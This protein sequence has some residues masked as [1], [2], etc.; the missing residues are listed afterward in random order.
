MIRKYIVL[1]ICGTTRL[2]VDLI[3]VIRSFTEGIRE[4]QCWI[5]HGDQGLNIAFIVMEGVF[6]HCLPVFVVLRIYRVETKN[7]DLTE[8]LLAAEQYQESN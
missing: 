2:G 3:F 1:I 8:S 7:I 4:K 6:T 5:G